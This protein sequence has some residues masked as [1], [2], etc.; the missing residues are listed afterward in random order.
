MKFDLKTLQDEILTPYE[1]LAFHAFK[2]RVDG[3]LL[4]QTK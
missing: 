1:V 2:V 3:M 4:L